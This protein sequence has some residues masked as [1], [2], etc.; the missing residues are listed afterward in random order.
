MNSDQEIIQDEV[1]IKFA[2]DSGDGMQ[3]TGKLFTENTAQAGND[4]A[5][6]PE[7]PSEIRAPIG[8][9]WGVSGFQ[10]HFGTEKIMTAGDK[11]DVLVAMNAA[12]LKSNLS[13][14]KKPAGTIIINTDGID[15]KNLRLAHYPDG[16]DPLEKLDN[17][18]LIKIPV[19]K[20]TKEC[21]AESPLGKKV[22]ER[23][24]NMFVL[25]YLL[26]RYNR[27]LDSSLKFLTY[28]FKSKPE[29][30][31]ANIRV[32]TSGFY[33]GETNEEFRSRYKVKPSILKKGTYRGITG[34]EALVFGLVTASKKSGL[35]LF[36]GSYPI[37]PASDILHYLAGLQ[38]LGVKTFQAEDEIAGICASLGASYGGSLGVTGTSGPGFVLKTET[39]GL[40]AMLELP[41]VV[42]NIQ[43]GGPSTG[44]PTKTEQS[45]LMMA[46]YG[47]NGECPI[48]VM[49][50]SHP[51]DAFHTA[52]EACR[53]AI[54]Y[55][56]PI[57]VLS[58]GY[59][60]NGAVPWKI[61]DIE[62]LPAIQVEFAQKNEGSPFLPYL[63]DDQYVRQWA[64][65]GTK[66]LEHQ[67]GGLEKENETGHVSYDPENHQLM[68]KL[69]QAKVDAIAND[70]PHQVINLGP[71]QGDILVLGWGSTYGV[72]EASV[73]QLIDK[74]HKVSHTH[75]K[76][77]LPLPQNLG[78]ILKSFDKVIIPELNNGQL[79]KLIREI[80][81]IPAISFC[82]IK[83]RPF[84]E[85]E[86]ISFITQQIE[87]G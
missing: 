54:K 48:P 29:L 50:V 39:L 5:T 83:G 46:L 19:T 6:F 43:R 10:V 16:F 72:I 74:G 70:I 61:P 18:E 47:R 22:I 51:T 49:A 9:V 17:Y 35:E 87:N 67:I 85:E 36:Y 44:L 71:K 33:F 82:Q 8:T 28:K 20:L 15:R 11:Y 86:L 37:T 77:L 76:Y 25:G 4:L 58:D 31:D 78:D 12:A 63:R 84:Y 79:V 21:L 57:I 66:G 69:R 45:D 34:A 30:Q 80:F 38:H 23:C 13:M 42:L 64:I 56:T 68:V 41:L 40:S 59:I 1:T 75:L 14:V 60:N 3:L 7:Y 81:L 73:K 55:M 52:F 24:K 2:G 32:L 65:P 26:W 62:S 53:I 27:P